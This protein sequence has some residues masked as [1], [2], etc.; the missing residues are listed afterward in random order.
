VVAREVVVPLWLYFV[1]HLAH[2]RLKWHS[3]GERRFPRHKLA[4]RELD[5][6]LTFLP[7]PVLNELERK[8]RELQ[9]MLADLLLKK[10]ALEAVWGGG[11][12]K[13][14]H[15]RAAA[16]NVVA[17]GCVPGGQRVGIWD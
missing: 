12:C 8:N 15:R 3:Y 14:A 2:R 17:A 9:Q 11:N 5:Y 10:P 4:R 16:E 7:S 13:P 6:S 1:G